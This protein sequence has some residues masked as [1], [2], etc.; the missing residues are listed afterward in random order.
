MPPADGHPYRFDWR[1]LKCWGI[2]EAILPP[3]STL[4]NK[5]FSLWDS[6]RWPIVGIVSFGF[7]ETLLIAGLIVNLRKRRLAEQ[8]T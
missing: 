4:I 6:Y 7:I 3:G 2:P 8:A 1:E 5:E